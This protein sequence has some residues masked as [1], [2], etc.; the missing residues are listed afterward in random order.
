MSAMWRRLGFALA[1]T[2]WLSGSAPLAAQDR[3]APAPVPAPDGLPGYAAPPDVV[4]EIRQSV[5]LAVSRFHAMDQAGLLAMV[6]PYYRTGTLTKAGIAEQL[7]TIFTLHDRVRVRVRVDDIRM[8]GD[9]AWVY[10]TGEV[11][12]RVRVLGNTIVVASW[13]RE[14]EVGRR[15]NGRWRLYGYQ[16]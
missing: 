7:R 1:L 9:T 16:R 12:G 13:D 2:V 8:V 10:S 15:E 11:T 14:L 4:V 5:D 6:S 3:P